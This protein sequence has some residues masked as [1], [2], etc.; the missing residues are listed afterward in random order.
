MLRRKIF[1][2]T[3]IRKVVKRLQMCGYRAHVALQDSC[4]NGIPARRLRTYGVALLGSRQKHRFHWPKTPSSRKFGFHQMISQHIGGVPFSLPS[5]STLQGRQRVNE[6]IRRCLAKHYPSESYERSLQICKETN[7]IRKPLAVDIDCSVG[8][9]VSTNGALMDATSHTLTVSRGARSGLWLFTHS[10]RF[11][12]DALS[13]SQGLEPGVDI[14][15]DVLLKLGVGECKWGKVMG[16]SMSLCVTER[17]LLAAGV[18][19]G[20]VS[21]DRARILDRWASGASMISPSWC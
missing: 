14:D 8:S 3:V 15:N 12:M 5:T 1:K 18:P 4:G 2:K 6:L 10:L 21:R 13:W 20:F 9:D 19:A 11:P 16:N 7:G 17:V